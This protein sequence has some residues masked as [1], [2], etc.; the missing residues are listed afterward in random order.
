MTDE[1]IYKMAERAVLPEWGTVMRVL[2]RPVLI[3]IAVQIVR[4]DPLDEAFAK[5]MGLTV[6]ELTDFVTRMLSS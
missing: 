5:R 4:N 6:D 3:D 2:M 1:E